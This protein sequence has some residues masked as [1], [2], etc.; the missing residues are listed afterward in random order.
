MATADSAPAT[1]NASSTGT[2]KSQSG[3]AVAELDNEM[4]L[5]AKH[6]LSGDGSSIKALEKLGMSFFL[7]YKQDDYRYRQSAKLR[8]VPCLEK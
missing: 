7:A 2:T 5:V 8:G 4:K 6:H 3:K 1:T